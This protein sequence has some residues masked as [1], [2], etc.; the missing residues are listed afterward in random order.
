MGSR[1]SGTEVFVF[2]HCLLPIASRQDRD[3]GAGGRSISRIA[4]LKE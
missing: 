3:A 4:M 1:Q 2:S